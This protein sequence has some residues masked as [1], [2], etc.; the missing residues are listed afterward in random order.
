MDQGL[1]PWGFRGIGFEDGGVRREHR[2]V[3]VSRLDSDVIRVL[4]SL[5]NVSRL[6]KSEVKVILFRCPVLYKIL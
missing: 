4:E 2:R 5:S 1:E 6:W 3:W